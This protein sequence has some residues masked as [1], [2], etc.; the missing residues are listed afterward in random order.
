[1]SVFKLFL[2]FTGLN[3]GVNSGMAEC[4]TIKDHDSR[5]MCF[6]AASGE[7][8]WCEFIHEH[9]MRVRC[10]MYRRAK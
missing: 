6:A 2:V 9:D 7:V 8:S 5:M 1:M 3:F 4:A 10:R